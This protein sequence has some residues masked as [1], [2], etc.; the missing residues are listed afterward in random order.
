[1]MFAIQKHAHQRGCPQDTRNSRLHFQRAEFFPK[2]AFGSSINPTN[3]PSRFVALQRLDSWHQT[4]PVVRHSLVTSL[5]SI[6]GVSTHRI[7][8][9]PF[10]YIRTFRILAGCPNA[11]TLPARRK[12]RHIARCP[13]RDSSAFGFNFIVPSHLFYSLVSAFKEFLSLHHG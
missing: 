10:P 13:P 1:M 7:L 12:F 11:N 4:P 5:D 3:A 9:R 2:L 8:N 6:E